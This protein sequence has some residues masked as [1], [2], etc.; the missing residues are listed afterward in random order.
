MSPALTHDEIDA[1]GLPKGCT[2]GQRPSDPAL[3]VRSPWK[4]HLPLAERQA[5]WRARDLDLGRRLVASLV[6]R[7]G[8]SEAEAEAAL[9]VTLEVPCCGH[10]GRSSYPVDVVAVYREAARRA[11]T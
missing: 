10:K 9:S 3:L 6:R 11:V 8:W 5:E 2:P 7:E 1:L 4:D